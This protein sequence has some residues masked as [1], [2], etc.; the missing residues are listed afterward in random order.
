MN[1]LQRVLIVSIL[2]SMVSGCAYFQIP[3]GTNNPSLSLVDIKLKK[4]NLIKQT[5]IA[6]LTI[7]NPNDFDLP[8][9]D[10]KVKLALEDHSLGEGI[11]SQN[12]VVPANG[13]A[14]FKM[15]INTNLFSNLMIIKKIIDAK[16]ETITY[17]INGSVDV[18]L[19]LFIRDIHFKKID[20]IATPNLRQ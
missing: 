3:Y 9:D 10:I 13:E 6:E 4:A 17:E 11:T 16:P 12:F 18:A 15:K 8:I 5:F 1:Y 7:E 20:T 14:T 2:L 19:P